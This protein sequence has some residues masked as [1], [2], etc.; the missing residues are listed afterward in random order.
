MRGIY[1][2]K[3]ASEEYISRL[4]FVVN[5]LVIFWSIDLVIYDV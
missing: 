5:T 3:D 2:G 1:N 4:L